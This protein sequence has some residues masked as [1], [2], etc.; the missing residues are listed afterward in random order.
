MQVHTRG[1]SDSVWWQA[2]TLARIVLYICACSLFYPLSAIGGDLQNGDWLANSFRGSFQINRSHKHT[3][4]EADVIQF[5]YFRMLSAID[6]GIFRCPNFFIERKACEVAYVLELFVDSHVSRSIFNILHDHDGEG[7]RTTGENYGNVSRTRSFYECVT[8]RLMRFDMLPSSLHFWE[9]IFF[10]DVSTL[11]D[12]SVAI[13]DTLRERH[14]I[15]VDA[16][17]ILHSNDGKEAPVRTLNYLATRYGRRSSS[18]FELQAI[19]GDDNFT[20]RTSSENQGG[21]T[22]RGAD[23]KQ[24]KEPQYMRRNDTGVRGFERTPTGQVIDDLSNADGK[25]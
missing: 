24:K 21:M 6:I 10:K 4:Q 3:P 18:R 22:N 16:F 23:K 25:T 15:V 8:G 9:G 5:F 12:G 7:I 11:Y 1:G 2:M 17:N 13:A 20:W 19:G 14:Q